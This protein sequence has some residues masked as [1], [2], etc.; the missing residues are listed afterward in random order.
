MNF[1][2]FKRPLAKLILDTKKRKTR[3]EY[4]GKIE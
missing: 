2:K 3:R 1:E 4:A